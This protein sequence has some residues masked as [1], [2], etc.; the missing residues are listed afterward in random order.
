MIT[1]SIYLPATATQIRNDLQH[2][3]ALRNPTWPLP[4]SARGIPEIGQLRK[5][6]S[7]PRRRQQLVDF[8]EQLLRGLPW[9]LAGEGL[10]QGDELY[11][12]DHLLQCL[13]NRLAP[14][15]L[16]LAGEHHDLGLR[17]LE[18]NRGVLDCGRGQR[19]ESGIAENLAQE[20]AHVG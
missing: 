2:H 9:V 10:V 16:N 19:V 3:P 12:G 17:G 20:R 4:R 15:I 6:G 14:E 18:Q 8:T 1:K 7:S 11:A 5:I 13:M